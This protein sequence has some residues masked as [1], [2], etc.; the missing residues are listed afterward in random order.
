MIA[1]LE[2]MLA[3][4]ADSA[5]LR[6]TLASS[7]RSAGDLERAAEHARAAVR[8]DADYSAAWRLLG[9]VQAEL[10]QHETAAE[11][12]RHGIEVAES[13]GDRQAAKE[14]RVFLK[15]LERPT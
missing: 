8:L 4:G 13:R 15:R 12:Y 11:T 6:F 2:K 9:R 5:G 10:G 1:N 3:G 7:Y 14:M